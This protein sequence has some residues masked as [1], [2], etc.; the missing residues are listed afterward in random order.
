MPNERV[1][2]LHLSDL[3]HGRWPDCRE[4]ILDDMA[5]RAQRFSAP[6]LILF[7]GDLT[8]DSNSLDIENLSTA[9]S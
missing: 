4:R 2:W 7:T 1:T 9:G 5:A 3:H 6:N 8:P